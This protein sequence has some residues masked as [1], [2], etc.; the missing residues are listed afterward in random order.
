MTTPKTSY[1][2]EVTKKVTIAVDI[3][4]NPTEIRWYKNNEL[5]ITTSNKYSGGTSF[6]PGLTIKNISV[7]DA[8]IYVCEATDGTDTVRSSII[9]LSAKSMLD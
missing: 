2:T 8:G 1:N 9:Q 7:S 3:K 6:V 4:G 5:L